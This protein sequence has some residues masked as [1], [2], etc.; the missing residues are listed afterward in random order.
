MKTT[1]IQQANKLYSIYSDTGNASMND[2]L[3]LRH[4]LSWEE[5]TSIQ[6]NHF[7]KLEIGIVKR[8]FEFTESKTGK[9]SKSFKQGEM[10]VFQ[11]RS[12]GLI[13]VEFYHNRTKSYTSGV[14]SSYN[15][16]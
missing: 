7:N 9:V 12:D 5:T 3:L 15:L 14:T 16:N 2:E 1:I 8:D 13:M 11:T 4:N 6:K 10:V